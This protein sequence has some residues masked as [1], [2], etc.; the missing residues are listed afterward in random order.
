MPCAEIIAAAPSLSG[1]AWGGVGAVMGNADLPHAGTSPLFFLSAQ[2][3]L[4][5]HAT[6]Q[7]NIKA[8]ILCVQ[9]LQW[10]YMMQPM[11][12]SHLDQQ[13]LQSKNINI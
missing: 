5:L 1:A 3:T 12:W 8:E 10:E 4:V 6:W 7:E 11:A 2:I 13:S 9:G